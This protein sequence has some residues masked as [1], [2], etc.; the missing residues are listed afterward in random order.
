[1][2]IVTILS[3]L[4]VPMYGTPHIITHWDVHLTK[5]L[6]GGAPYNSW[7]PRGHEIA[8]SW[9]LDNSN[10]TTVFSWYANNEL[11]FMVF[12]NQQTP[13][14]GPILTLNFQRGS[15][16]F[17][18]GFSTCGPFSWLC[19]KNQ[20]DPT[21]IMARHAS[22]IYLISKPLKKL[23]KWTPRKMCSFFL[24]FVSGNYELE[25]KSR[26]GS[27]GCRVRK[28]DQ[29]VLKTQRDPMIVARSSTATLATTKWSH[30]VI[31]W[32]IDVYRLIQSYNA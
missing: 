24:F 14:G 12:I 17:H 15:K 4:G 10:F 25:L 19:R 3:S 22:C 29:P 23:E 1:M 16:W 32:F 13:L 27:A 28:R 9:C 11:V 5:P 20:F 2:E 6:K 26:I 30:S 7:G 31:N 21:E 18:H 8:I